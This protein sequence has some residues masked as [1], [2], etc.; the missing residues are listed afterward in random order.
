MRNLKMNALLAKVEHA[1]S[2]FRKMTSE[3][4]TFFTKSQGSFVGLRKTY[5]PREG[6]VDEP[7]MRQLVHVTTTVD[8]KMNWYEANASEY[9]NSTL[10]VDA[11]NASNGI[12]TPLMVNGALV[13]RLSTL[14]L[15]KLKSI[16]TKLGMEAM[17]AAIPVRTDTIIWESS[18]EDT[19]SGRQIYANER[20]SGVRRGGTK[21]EYILEDPNIKYMM[22]SGKVPDVTKYTP[23]TAYKDNTVEIG[24]Y[25]LQHFSGEYTQRQKAEILKRRSEL[26]EGVEIALKEANDVESV[27]SELTSSIL[28]DFIHRGIL[29][30]Q[31]SL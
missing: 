12:R 23:K 31:T 5:E 6:T 7:S 27:K 9:I 2:L 30:T 18:T 17:Y 10:A 14:E 22:D 19:Y 21:T 11:T 26:L 16:L 3:Y 20:V 25:T 8:E 15:M 24:D 29:P 28:F 13:A 4:L 1:G